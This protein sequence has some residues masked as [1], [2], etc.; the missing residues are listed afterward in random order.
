MKHR[1]QSGTL[2]PRHGWWILRYRQTVN[3]GGELKTTQP[4]LQLAP[5][6]AQYG[7]GKKPT[8]YSLSWPKNT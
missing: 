7:K 8:P 6:C 5:Q 3:G 2:Y 4:A 1:E